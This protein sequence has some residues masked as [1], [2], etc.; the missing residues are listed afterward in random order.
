MEIVITVRFRLAQTRKVTII[1]PLRDPIIEESMAV[2]ITNHLIT[3]QREQ[4]MAHSALLRLRWRTF[5]DMKT[6]WSTMKKM[7]FKMMEQKA[8]YMKMIRAILCLL[9]T[10]VVI[11]STFC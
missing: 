7:C 1:N 4:V 6:T 8:R 2:K 3:I 9:K 10:C 5:L 11:R